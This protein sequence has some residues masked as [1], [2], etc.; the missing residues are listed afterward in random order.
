MS[1]VIYEAQCSLCGGE[2]QWVGTTGDPDVPRKDSDRIVCL[3]C[4]ILD[5][6]IQKGDPNNDDNL[7]AVD[8]RIH[9]ECPAGHTG[10]L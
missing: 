5:R 6:P 7:P 8:V 9:R 3:T 4:H 2:V 10:S 1:T